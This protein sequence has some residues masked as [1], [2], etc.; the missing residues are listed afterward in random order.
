MN[1]LDIEPYESRGGATR[2]VFRNNVTS[3]YSHSSRFTS[4]FF[5]ANG[6][7]GALV[8]DVRVRRN[9]V[10]GQPLDT[11]V[12]DEHTGY[13]GQR[14]RRDITFIDNRSTVTARWGPVLHFKHVDHVTVRDNR[15]RV[16]DGP[17]ARFID[18]TGI[19]FR[20]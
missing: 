17:L 19:R 20:R 18:S 13:H 15:Q 10:T 1:V 14:N 11:L 5:A 8:R 9:L 6:T 12:G 7:H 4:F 16:T 2:I 3:T